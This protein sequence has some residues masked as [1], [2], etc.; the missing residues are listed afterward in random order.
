MV[1]LTI[2]DLEC[3]PSDYPLSIALH[4]PHYMRRRGIRI[5]VRA[6]GGSPPPQSGRIF[7]LCR[8]VLN[9]WSFA[10][11][12]INASM[13]SRWRMCVR[14]WVW[15]PCKHEKCI[16]RKCSNFA[17]TFG[18]WFL[19]KRNLCSHASVCVCVWMCVCMLRPSLEPL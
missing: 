12:V 18:F 17:N 2:V 11:G 15:L 5:G 8:A 19:W 3:T 4:Y 16:E 6:G 9:Y 14:L 10:E 7:T 1:N 13:Q